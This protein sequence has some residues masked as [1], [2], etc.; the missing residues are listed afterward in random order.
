MN[1]KILKSTMN[2]WIPKISE[3]PDNRTVVLEVVYNNY[4]QLK[5][6]PMNTPSQT[7]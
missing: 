1:N 4:K 5:Y 3:Y 6:L 2:I 7:K